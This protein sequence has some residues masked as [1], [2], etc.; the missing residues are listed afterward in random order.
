MGAGRKLGHDGALRHLVEFLKQE[1]ADARSSESAT[2]SCTAGSTTP[3]P[4][5]STKVLAALEELI[6]LA[7]LHQPHNL[8][9]IRTVCS[10]VLPDLPQVACF[11]TAFHRTNP[12]IAQRFAIPAE[13]HDAG[14]RRYG[15]HGLSY[16]YIASILPEYDAKAALG[17]TVV[18]TWA[19]ARACARFGQQAASR[20]R[21]GSRRSTACRW[22]L[23]PVRSTPA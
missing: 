20:A 1:L 12:D 23:A 3:S 14:V 9:P 22:E 10:T 15:F 7:P 21:W 16:E 19:T 17:R 5:A 8:A 4:C 2:A 6:P 18:C 13:L 11:D